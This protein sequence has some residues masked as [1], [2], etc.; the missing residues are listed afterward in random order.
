MKKTILSLTTASFL[1]VA[2]CSSGNDEKTSDSSSNTNNE[3][4]TEQT[5]TTESNEIASSA[6]IEVPAEINALL[7]KNTCLSC[8][9][10]NEKVVGPA[11]KE[12]AKRNYTNEQIV[13][14]I[15]K[16]KP[17]NWPDYPTPMVGLPNVPKAE[18]LK[19]AEWINS[20]K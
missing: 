5:T 16:P 7:E 6:S 12:V 2:A 10:A 8:H 17:S 4:N 13:E 18:A 9:E 11:Y 20:L 15:Y 3:I 14:L 19:I 1:I